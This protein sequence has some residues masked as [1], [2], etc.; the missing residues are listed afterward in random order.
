MR[1][2][3]LAATVVLSLLNSVSADVCS[4]GP[5]ISTLAGIPHN[6]N[7]PDRKFCEGRWD[8]GNVITGIRVWWAKFHI[9]AVQFQFAGGDW[10]AVRGQNDE[11][12][13]P[14]QYG[15]KTWD[16]NASIGLELWNNKPDD[17]DPMDAVGYI[18]I[19]EKG[20]DDF[21]AGGSKTQKDSIKVNA[22]SGKLLAVQGAAGSFVSTLEFHFLESVIKN[23]EMT[24]IKFKE[25]V[26]K[27][28]KEKK[29][30][31]SE[32]VR[33]AAWFKNSDKK[34]TSSK[35]YS[36]TAGSTR[37][38]TKTIT[39]ENSHTF[40]FKV[41]VSIESTIK[42][43]LLTE[44]KATVATEA[45]YT[46]TTMK[47]EANTDSNAFPISFNIGG[48]IAPQEAVRC[49]QFIKTGTFES[50]YEA[51]MRAELE[52]GKSFEYKDFGDF[53]SVGH[54]DAVTECK[55][56]A[57]KDVPDFEEVEEA[58]SKRSSRL[59]RFIGEA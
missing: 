32:A 56:F 38:N 4:K 9:K 35:T 1:F 47:S 8:K 52:N 27:W 45:S 42:V 6:K 51:V 28:N 29:G 30:I 37:T 46:D 22:G 34:G 55:T 39:T 54:A 3:S 26:S 58:K 50:S 49:T 33:V 2:F 44:I 17:G 15:E 57:L 21:D 24:D 48:Q 23:I 7:P 41:G 11:D 10:G 5:F 18:R 12:T 25:D 59:A 40:G 16:E 19:T 36:Q 20:K 14:D 53:V 43:P 31:E 13:G